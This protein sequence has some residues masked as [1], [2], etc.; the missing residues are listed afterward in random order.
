MT[1]YRAMLRDIAITALKGKPTLADQ[2]V[3][4]PN[5]APTWDGEYPMIIVRTPQERKESLSRGPPQ[6]N[7]VATL[8]VTARLEGATAEEAEAKLEVM[9]EQIECTLI[10]DYELTRKIQQFSFVDTRMDF[11]GE[12]QAHLGQLTVNIGLEFFQGPEDFAPIEAVPIEEMEITAD[13]AVPFDRQGIY[14]DPPF[15]SSVTSPP[16]TQG[17]DGRAETGLILNFP[18]DKNVD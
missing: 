16:R 8:Q 13:M 5:D 9:A 4:S 18:E 15:P 3:F 12:G 7:V 14:K 6:F 10:N 11:S 17:P 2:R 1:L